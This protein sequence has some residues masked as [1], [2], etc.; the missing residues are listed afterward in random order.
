MGNSV[1]S[2]AMAA[3]PEL[4]AVAVLVLGLV[5]ARLASIAVGYGLAALDRRVSRMTTSEASVLTPRLISL[6][7][8][9]VFWL[10]LVLAVALAAR[11]LGVGGGLAVLNI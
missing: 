8:T 4:A 1:V 3:H 5:V 7:R 2:N 11:V 6:S 10:L 9:F